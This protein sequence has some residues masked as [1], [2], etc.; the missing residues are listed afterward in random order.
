MTFDLDLFITINLRNE[1]YGPNY[2]EMCYGDLCTSTG[3]KLTF[4][5][6][7]HC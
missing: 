2:I 7:P 6:N 5:I 4:G 1:L 3:L